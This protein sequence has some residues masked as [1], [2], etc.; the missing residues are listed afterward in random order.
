VFILAEANLLA[1]GCCEGGLGL[2]WY[3]VS[4]GF[5]VEKSLGD[6]ECIDKETDCSLM[7]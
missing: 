7:V 1:A 6:Y 5:F 4:K 3:N 2:V